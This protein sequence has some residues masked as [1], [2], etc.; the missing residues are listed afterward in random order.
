M[1][2]IKWTLQCISAE[3]GH[4]VYQA[5]HRDGGPGRGKH[6]SLTVDIDHNQKHKGMPAWE[7]FRYFEP[8]YDG[9]PNIVTCLGMA[10][11]QAM[12]DNGELMNAYMT[13]ATDETG[14]CL[15]NIPSREYRLQ[16]LKEVRG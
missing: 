3:H 13:A 15:P 16:H 1:V 14:N 7:M 4:W 5:D 9:P 2:K 8:G 12:T 10:I 6:V 11:H